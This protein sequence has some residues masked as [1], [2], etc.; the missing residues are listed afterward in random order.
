VVTEESSAFQGAASIRRMQL[1]YGF[2]EI[3][4]W[5]DLSQ[6]EHRERISRRLRLMGTQ[7]IRIFVFDQPV[8]DPIKEWHLF[9]DFVQAILDA[10]ARPMVTFAKF[11]PPYDNPSNV[12]NFVARCSE[13]V[14]GCIEQWG[15]DTV[16]DWY[17]CVWNE[18]NNLIIGGDLSF[19]QYRRVYEEVAA[20]V[21]QLVEP[22]LGGRK[23]LIGGPA[24]DGTH[25][26]YWMDWIARLVTEVDDRM[27]GFVSWHRYGDWRPAV[28]S[29]TLDLEMWDAPDPPTGVA[30]EALLMAQTPDYEARARGV[31][32]LLKGRDILNVC[33]ELNTISHHEQYYT[34]GLNQNAL[35]AAYYASALI[36]LLRGGADLEMRWTATGHD[37]AYGLMTRTGEP[38]P[39]CLAKQLFAQHVR[40]GD[41]IRFPGH[42]LDAPDIDAVVAWDD[43]GRRSG[44]FVN[45]AARPR[46]LTIPD[47]DDRLQGCETVMRLDTSTGERVVREP[48]DGT[49]RLKGYGVAVV[50]NGASE[51]ELD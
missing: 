30:F 8:P 31:A 45:T 48:F 49:I 46:A 23:A 26:S 6:G 40:Y 13:V 3:Y 24:I 34:L 41:W 36:H 25:R 17:W 42:R 51:T 37:D 5:W 14:W 22:Y 44:V 16:K 38:T 33:G 28:P 12:R 10:G 18:P 39:A 2:N 15:G 43:N 47:W 35:G 7:V 29:A 50:T 11:P 9:A 19:S 1:R 20:A 27:V 32:R 4:G 21:L